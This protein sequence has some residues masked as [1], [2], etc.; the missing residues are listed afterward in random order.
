MKLYEE[1]KF[2][3]NM[4]ENLEEARKSN[5]PAPQVIK[6]VK[7]ETQL[8][9]QYGHAAGQYRHYDEI[10]YVDPIFNVEMT[11]TVWQE[12]PG[13]GKYFGWGAKHSGHW[14]YAAYDYDGNL[15]PGVDPNSHISPRIKTELS[16]VVNKIN[17]P[18]EN[19]EE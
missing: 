15:L 13:Y 19:E 12:Q 14:D 10:T 16:K 5:P 8:Q 9:K 2:Y 6:I 4:W 17:N 11:A 3:E 18:T 7:I 1:F